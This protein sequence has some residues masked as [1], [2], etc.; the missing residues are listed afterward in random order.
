MSAVLL[1]LPV[2]AAGH[3]VG[4]VTESD[5][6]RVLAEELGPLAQAA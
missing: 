1:S 2:V 4:I 3:M 5:L 6:F